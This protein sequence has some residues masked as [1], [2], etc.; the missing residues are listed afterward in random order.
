MLNIVLGV[1]MIGFGIEL[2]I[3]PRWYSLKYS[4]Y[5][6]FAG[7]NYLFGSACIL[8]GLIFLFLEGRRR[9]RGKTPRK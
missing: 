8:W 1:V 7:S 4:H 5:F 9:I 6:D 2:Y 3:Q